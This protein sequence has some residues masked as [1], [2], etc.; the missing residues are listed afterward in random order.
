MKNLRRQPGAWNEVS[1]LVMSLHDLMSMCVRRHDFPAQFQIRVQVLRC[2]RWMK[3]VKV[4]LPSFSKVLHGLRADHST[5]LVNGKE[6]RLLS[7]HGLQS[8]DQVNS[9]RLGVAMISHDEWCECAMQA[10]K[11]A[12]RRVFCMVLFK[13]RSI[14]CCS[15]APCL[16][17]SKIQNLH[18]QLGE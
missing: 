5:H 2:Q 1:R 10:C 16:C 12:C 11:Q 8:A 9:T 7:G 13:A 15:I 17:S 6:N 18:A 14:V 3:E 4:H